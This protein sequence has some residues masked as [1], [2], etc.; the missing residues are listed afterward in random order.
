MTSPI[1]PTPKKTVLGRKHV[2]W[3][4][5]RKN[6]R[7]GSTWAQDREKRTGKQQSPKV[8]YFPYLGEAPAGPI[9]PKS[10]VMGGVYHI[11]TCA[12]FQIEIFMGYDFT[13]GRIFDCPI[14]FLHWPYNT[15]ALPVIIASNN[16][17]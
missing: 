5:Q 2:I 6:Q 1:V 4:I 9:R 8:L 15:N 14:D 10:C 12:K 7:D 11:I 16:V 13:G 3:A 17:D